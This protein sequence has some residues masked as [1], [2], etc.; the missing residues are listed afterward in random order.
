MLKTEDNEL[1]T[2]VGPGTPMGE[3]FRRFWLP[4]LMPRELPAPDCPPV[5]VRLLG[6]DLVA[7]RDTEGRIGV[8]Q[9]FCPH[10][11]ASLFFGRNEDCGLRCVYHGWK[12][13]VDGACVDM[14][15]EPAETD[16]KHKV[17]M[18]A[19]P[20]M[21]WGGFIW[22]YMGPPERKPSPPEY[23]WAL[24]P[25]DQ[26]WQQKWCY[27]ANYFQ[28][29]E[30]EIDTC[31]TSFLHAYRDQ[32]QLAD[33]LAAAHISWQADKAPKLTVKRAEY[34]LYYGSRR[35]L[36][37]GRYNW[38]ITQWLLPTFSLIPQP[39]YPV[40]CRGYVPIDDENTWVFNTSYNREAPLSAKDVEMLESGM[41]AAPKLI[42]GTFMPE[43]NR[44]NDYLLDREAQRRV[45]STGIPGVNNQDRALVE[46]MGPIVDRSK[47]HLGT[48]DAA[49]ILA[50]RIM[51]E[52]A[53]ALAQ[54]QEPLPTD[55]R[56]F[57]VRSLDM[58]SA[59]GDLDALVAAHGADLRVA[60]A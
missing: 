7:F 55:G 40:S 42:P 52:H 26:R 51:L 35:T 43:T 57:R 31:H 53:R 21:E 17:R 20:T 41:T 49:V 44:S 16:F 48:T 3:V 34:G 22:V 24:L 54:G 1:L 33:N 5:R 12:F 39:G 6:E 59:I 25:D 2:R 50:R 9:E 58:A 46:T 14:P 38:R 47:E 30:G 32:S 37:D 11:R 36:G 8:L 15:S 18:T 28:G 60:A 19:Y 4:A 10:R 13:D 23:E 27:E 56:I 45:S 29:M